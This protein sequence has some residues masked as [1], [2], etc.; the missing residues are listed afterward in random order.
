MTRPYGALLRFG[1]IVP[2][3][4]AVVEP[5]IAS[6]M[7][8]GSALYASRLPGTVERETGRGLDR[9]IEGYIAALP[10]VVRAFGGME[11]DALCLMHTGCSYVAGLEAESRLT[12]AL[13][14][15]G[16][17][18]V[19]TAAEA[20]AATLEALGA[21][22]I[23]LVVPYPDW[24]AEASSAYWTER[25]FRVMQVA[26]PRDIV[27]IYEISFDAVVE[28][29]RGIDTRGTDAIL[30]TG[31]GMPTVEALE[32]CARQCA[33]PVISAN[34]CAAW[35]ALWPR[36]LPETRLHPILESLRARLDGQA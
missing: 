9:R 20:G 11:L 12:D 19:F 6:L 26:R 32:A 34:Q 3:A 29:V 17:A 21:R 23:A 25:G 36:L 30:L 7:P 5:E 4:N 18:H 16:A 2:P 24:L 14:L 31:T 10:D 28:V 8:P 22:R 33:V 15:S 1:L 27:S 35:H 13:A